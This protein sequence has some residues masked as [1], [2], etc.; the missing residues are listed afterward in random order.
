MKTDKFLSFRPVLLGAFA[1]ALGSTHA[2][3][4]IVSCGGTI[5]EIVFALGAGD[6]VVAVD[7]SSVYPEDATK[8]PQVGYVRQLSTEGILSVKPDL[9]LVNED[10]GPPE[11]LTQVEQLGVKT[12]KIDTEHT[13]EAAAQ[14]IVAVG[15]ALGIKESA[16]TLADQLTADIKEVQQAVAAMPAKPKVLFLYARGGGIMNV[17][18]TNT[19]A[20]SIIELAGGTNAVTGYEGYKPLTAEAAVAAAPDFILVTTRGL[21]SSGGV[22]GVL[23]QPGLAMTPAGQTEGRIISMDDLLLLG[24]GP[25]LGQAAQELSKKLHP[26]VAQKGF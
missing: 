13:P 22:E 21:E 14:R 2:A 19:S 18:G 12:L 17:A 20:D 9:F 26:T 6:R 1:L 8:L 24:F 25:R 16:Q 15:E 5:T 11:T 10:G 7:S 23:K 4:R 3:D